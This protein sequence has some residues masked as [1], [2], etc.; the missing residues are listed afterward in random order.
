M[1][2]GPGLSNFF[3]PTNAGTIT[4]QAR[5]SETPEQLGVCRI[6]DIE[7]VNHTPPAPHGGEYIGEIN[8]MLSVVA[9]NLSNGAIKEI[10]LGLR[11]RRC[12]EILVGECDNR[13]VI[14]QAFYLVVVFGSDER[15]LLSSIRC[16]YGAQ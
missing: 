7:P 5:T 10:P 15:P 3:A 12:G 2:R 14:V 8:L 13:G 9:N 11:C 6:C 4:G 1:R 16:P